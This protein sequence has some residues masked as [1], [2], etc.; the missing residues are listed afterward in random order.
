MK[1]SISNTLYWF[2]I[3]LLAVA[4]ARI[5]QDAPNKE[6]LPIGEEST[7]Q[8]II[9][10]PETKTALSEQ[11]GSVFHINWSEDDLIGVFVNRAQKPSV[12]KLQSGAG[13]THATFKGAGKG[14]ENVAIFPYSSASSLTGGIL[15]FNLPAQQSYS[16]KSFGLNSFPMLGTGTE[17]LTFRNL[18]AVLKLSLKGRVKVSRIIF[19]ANDPDAFVSGTASVRADGNFSPQLQMGERGSNSVALSCDV[20][21]SQDNVTDFYM[22]LPPQTYRGGF[23]IQI[24]T[25]TGSMSRKTRSD[26]TFS[27]SELRAVPV[28]EVV[29]DNGAVPSENLQ[30]KG[31]LED[32]FLIGTMEDLLLMNACVNSEQ[33]II[34]GT[35]KASFP[36]DGAEVYYKLSRNIDLSNDFRAGKLSWEPIGKEATQ[37]FSAHFDGN[38]YR[39]QGLYVNSVKEPAGLF[40]LLS[41]GAE[42]RNL[43]V[44]GTVKGGYQAGLLAGRVYGS[45]LVDNCVSRGSVEAEQAAGGLVGLVQAATLNA[46]RN[47]ASITSS[48]TGAGGITGESYDTFLLNCS[49]M[50]SVHTNTY[51]AGGIVGVLHSGDAANC[52]NSGTVSSEG[53]SGGI[54]G[55]TATGYHYNCLNIGDIAG[56]STGES[57]LYRGGISGFNYSGGASQNY[58]LYDPVRQQGFSLIGNSFDPTGN[59]SCTLAQLSG[60]HGNIDGYYT[61]S[62]GQPYYY[63]LDALNA[64]CAD[65]QGRYPRPLRAWGPGGEGYPVLVSS[66]AQRPQINLSTFV[67]LSEV[68]MRVDGRENTI[69]ISVL[70]GVEYPMNRKPDWITLTQESSSSEGNLIRRDYTFVVQ[71]NPDRQPRKGFIEFC[72]A[73]A[74]CVSTDIFQSGKAD[75]DDAWFYRDFWHSSLVFAV[76]NTSRSMRVDWNR[77]RNHFED[78]MNLAVLHV[79]GEFFTEASEAIYDKY[80]RMD[81]ILLMVD[82]RACVS[83]DTAADALSLESEKYGTSAGISFTSSVS[84]SDVQVDV[85]LHMKEKGRYK[86]SVLLLEDGVIAGQRVGK[87][88]VYMPDYVHNNVLRT[89][90]NS[91]LQ[92]DEFEIVQDLSVWERRFQGKLNK[93]WDKKKLK[94]LVYV[95]R[96]YGAGRFYNVAEASYIYGDAEYYIDNSYEAPLGNKAP[97]RFAD[98]ASLQRYYQSSDYSQNGRVTLLQKA[99][100][101]K[102][103]DFIIVGEAFTDR[104]QALFVEKATGACEAI[105]AVEPYGSLRNRFNVYALNAVSSNGMIGQQTLF[106]AAFG[107]GTSISCNTTA[108]F[109][110]VK[111]YLPQ[112]DVCRGAVVAL[113][114]DMKYAGTCSMFADNATVAMVTLDRDISDMGNTLRHELGHG[115]GKLMDEYV[116]YWNEI[117]SIPEFDC[118]KFHSTWAWGEN[119]DFTSN[120]AQIKWSR[121]LQDPLYSG[122]VGIYEGAY[123]YASG[124]YRP[125]DNSIMRYNTGYYNAPSRES[126]YK[127]IMALSEGENWVYRYSDFTALDAKGRE[128]WE[129]FYGNAQTV[130]KATSEEPENFVPLAPPIISSGPHTCPVR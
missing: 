128:E 41:E 118:D 29:L 49:N 102:G 108:V 47:F 15:S 40:G 104:D 21:L 32:P 114:N 70:S 27:R 65:N 73:S 92:G 98:D 3:V 63:L 1:R 86:I 121:F 28:M 84:G 13:T 116:N 43:E 50:G 87:D 111:R 66:E 120:P 69:K 42:I 26:I 90:L 123:L 124:A 64:W 122:Q 35:K 51:Y 10:E 24:E 5:E 53:G 45:I 115:F 113:I 2:S 54:S 75:G 59:Y 93:S 95:Q 76:G 30:G 57:Q 23:T 83:S 89:C 37:G 25:P 22:V 67:I 55:R 88:G 81:D 8:A 91:Q 17:E 19:T 78:G 96:A 9:G 112:V 130:T 117:P 103:I 107:E 99:S 34:P 11:D 129:S 4:C 14:K 127:K 105:F 61:D 125:S 16:L 109:S 106:S 36:A 126:I 56:G 48:D 44:E 18:C 72:N 62:K 85:K 71:A 82:G 100:M 94:V 6:Q 60:A 97:L 31:S 52:F 77:I 74:H 110:F 33:K 46:C 12:F 39:I 7:L 80:Y 68:E 119:V 58:W 101:G 38:G 20:M 79:G